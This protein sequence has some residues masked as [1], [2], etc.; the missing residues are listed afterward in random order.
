M[1][2]ERCNAAPVNTPM[3]L[4]DAYQSHTWQLCKSCAKSWTA[5]VV[6]WF[7]AG[8]TKDAGETSTKGAV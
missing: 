6:E 7:I 8:R 4:V 3:T 1:K 5:L 2:C